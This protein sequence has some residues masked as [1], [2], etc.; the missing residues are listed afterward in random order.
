MILLKTIVIAVPVALPSSSLYSSAINAKNIVELTNQTRKNLGLEPLSVSDKLAIAATNKAKDMVTK[1]YFA[2]T[3]PDGKTPWVW[4]KDVGY[5]Y[6][7]AG[8]NLAVHFYEA[9]DVDAGWMAS[10]THRA[11]IVNANYTEIG[12]GTAS[13]IFDG[14]NS[15]FVVQMFGRPALALTSSNELVKTQVTVPKLTSAEENNIKIAQVNAGYKIQVD[16]PDAKIVNVQLAGEEINLTPVTDK[17]TEW[18]GV[19]PFNANVMGASG[20]PI[21]LTTIKDGAL[22]ETK[23][24]ALV[25]PEVKT[26]KLYIFNEG[27]KQFTTLFGFLHIGNLDDKIRQFYVIFSIVLSAFII[28]YIFV[29]RFRI[30]NSSVISHA[31]AVITLAVFLLLI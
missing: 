31:M 9:E 3:S 22:P 25:A 30:K 29:L 4:I 7:Y 11:N 14:V 10:P 17:P 18:S 16:A 19:I 12:V 28:M 1:S 26:Q 20:E 21:T 27:D 8:E 6:S 13:G 15:T 5:Q 24:V 23:Q 2:H